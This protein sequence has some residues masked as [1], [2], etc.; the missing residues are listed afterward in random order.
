DGGGDRQRIHGPPGPRWF[1]RDSAIARVPGDAS[2]FVGGMRAVILQTLHPAAMRAVAEHSG[3]R[4]DM[5]GRLARTSRFLAVTNFWH[6]EEAHHA[7]DVAR[8]ARVYDAASTRGRPATARPAPPPPRPCH[9][10]ASLRPPLRRLRPASP[11]LGA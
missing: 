1:P 3:F 4:G 8:A 6:A 5:W 10:P 9:P 7:V 11:A 2:M